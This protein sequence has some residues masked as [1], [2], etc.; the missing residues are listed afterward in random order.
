VAI[1][2]RGMKKLHQNPRKG[3]RCCVSRSSAT[4]KPC[5]RKAARSP[6]ACGPQPRVP[7]PERTGNTLP[8][9]RWKRGGTIMP[10][11]ATRALPENPPA[12]MRGKAGL[13]TR[14]PVSG[15]WKPSARVPACPS[16]CF[17]LLPPDRRFLSCTPSVSSRSFCIVLLNSSGALWTGRGEGRDSVD[18]HFERSP[19][20][21]G[22]WFGSRDARLMVQTKSRSRIAAGASWIRSLTRTIFPVAMD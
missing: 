21:G 13:S 8:P 2:R 19:W 14:K 15:S 6:N 4:S 9:V 18:T 5:V 11:K 7:G 10:A 12:G 20:R 1:N 3:S 22:P 17:S 16:P